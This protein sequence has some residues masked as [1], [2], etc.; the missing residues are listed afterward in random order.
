M[1]LGPVITV[2]GDIAPDELGAT[3]VHEHL[4]CDISIHSGKAD[5]R[6]MDVPLVAE[7]LAPFRQAG[8]CS[9]VEVTP[10]GIGRNPLKLREIS[11]LSGVS[12]ISGI[13]FYDES[14]YPTWLHTATVDQIEDYFVR[15]IEEGTDGVRAGLIGELTSHNETHPNPTGYRLREPETRVFQAAA[16]AQEHTGVA[17]STHAALGR[18]GHA[19]LD[20]LEQAGANLEKVAIGHCDAHWHPDIER[21]LAYY[22]PILERG[23]YCQFD[24]IGWTQFAPDE[25]RAERIKALVDLGYEKQIMLS[26][27]TFRQSQLHRNGGRGFD[28]LWRS[29][30]PRLRKRGLSDTQIHSMSVEAPRNLLPRGERGGGV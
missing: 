27:D 10:E 28:F 4:Y 19:Q 14:T 20:V 23:A 6:V 15:Q 26:T 1:R 12:I 7:E 25:A 29:F 5:N 22:L 24:L 9:V 2:T 16:S 13:A 3:L 11:Q 18:G 21:D 8:G 17:I 30:L